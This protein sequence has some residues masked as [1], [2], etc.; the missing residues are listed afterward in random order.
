MSIVQAAKQEDQGSTRALPFGHTCRTSCL[1][2][3][4]KPLN[5]QPD[6]SP[7]LRATKLQ[8]TAA[9]NPDPVIQ[10]SV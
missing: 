9:P 1:K 10:K 2:E 7:S 4:F 8:A 5:H 3:L 6:P